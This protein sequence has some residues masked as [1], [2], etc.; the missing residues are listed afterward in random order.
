MSRA[1][2]VALLTAPPAARALDAAPLVVLR[3]AAQVAPS[4]SGHEAWEAVLDPA[5]LTAATERL[6]LGL[7]PGRTV[8]AHRVSVETR[9][10]DDLVTEAGIPRLTV[11]RKKDRL[12]FLRPR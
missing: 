8:T 7:T 3:F 10:P 12:L 1:A 6:E 2:L 4:A 9:G 5:V 11:D